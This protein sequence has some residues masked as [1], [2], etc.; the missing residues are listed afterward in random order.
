MSSTFY[1]VITTTGRWL[2]SNQNS[3]KNLSPNLSPEDGALVSRWKDPQRGQTP[4]L[5]T[6]GFHCLHS[7]LDQSAEITRKVGNQETLLITELTVSTNGLA[8]LASPP[9]WAEA[10]SVPNIAVTAR[11]RVRQQCMMLAVRHTVHNWETV[12]LVENQTIPEPVLMC[13]CTS[14]F[15][16]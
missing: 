6:E 12:T 4:H 2:K 13:S 16:L 10:S 8:L 7:P 9:N 1:A 14:H 11:I 5:S 15:V 3:N